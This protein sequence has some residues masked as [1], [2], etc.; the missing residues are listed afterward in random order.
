M[1]DTKLILLC[2]SA[3]L[4]LGKAKTVHAQTNNNQLKIEESSLSEKEL[5]NQVPKYY[6][7]AVGINSSNFRDFATSPLIYNGSALHFSL[8]RLKIGN[9]RE[10][11]LGLSYDSGTYATNFNDNTTTSSVKRIELNYSRLY[12][13]GLFKSEKYNTKVGFLLSGNGNLRT[14]ASLQNNATGVDI[15]ANLLGSIKITKD[16]SRT[17]PKEKK[18]LFWK[19]K[20]DAVKRNLA[21]RLNAGL[22][23]SSY[24][25][26]Y[27]YSGQSAVLND[28]KLFDDYEY[29]IFSGFRA[30]SSLDYTCY[31]KNKNAIRFSY[32]WD[33]Y[34]TGGDLDKFEMAHHILKFTLLFNTNNR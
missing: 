15:F 7:I 21:F 28:A 13:V 20:R 6:G 1:I 34:S 29:K 16:I 9:D 23:N 19:F 3:F 25:N 24:R 2:L 4:F 11:E 14:N 5:R 32:V 26:G 33:A 18:F 27:V 22:V 10:A 30:S 17:A 31:L 12:Q 8:A